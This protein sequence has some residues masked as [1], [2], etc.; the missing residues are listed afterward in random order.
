MHLQHV[1][2]VNSSEGVGFHRHNAAAAQ[3]RGCCLPDPCNIITRSCGQLN[4]AFAQAAQ[5]P[6]V[7]AGM[8][9]L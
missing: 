8:H 1:P 7:V 5:L 3:A 6:V 2:Q 4:R 9:R